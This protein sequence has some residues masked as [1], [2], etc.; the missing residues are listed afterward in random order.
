MSKVNLS[1]EE[2][3]IFYKWCV[4]R[5][6]KNKNVIS[7]TTGST[8]SGKSYNDLRKAEIHYRNL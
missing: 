5:I 7:G 3:E 8:G 2:G 6:K 4:G 1:V